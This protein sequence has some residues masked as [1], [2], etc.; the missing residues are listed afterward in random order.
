VT[1]QEY[2]RILAGLSKEDPKYRITSETA[3]ASGSPNNPGRESLL[4][5]LKGDDSLA[6]T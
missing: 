1:D 4:E 5:V 2:T 6:N 3:L